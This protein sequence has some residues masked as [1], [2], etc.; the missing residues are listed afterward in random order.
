MKIYFDGCSF[1]Y[2]SEL[3]DRLKSRYSRLLCDH[4]DA[5]EYNI[6]RGGGS[7]RRIARN[8]LEHDLSQYDMVVLQ[9]TKRQRT[10]YYSYGHWQRVSWAKVVKF[11]MLSRNQGKMYSMK[12]GK[13]VETEWNTRK[14]NSSVFWGRSEKNDKLEDPKEIQ[15]KVNKWKNKSLSD[16]DTNYKRYMKDRDYWETYYREIYN[17]DYGRSEEK[18][19]YNLFKGMLKDKPHVILSIE[20]EPEVPVDFIIGRNIPRVRSKHDSHPNEEGH[21]IICQEILKNENLL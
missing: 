8:L 1:T 12:D 9:M 5:E 13:V 19:Y 4:F 6:A 3:K 2:G 7:N 20:A 18:I 11:G 17:D 21:Q 14:Q 16:S 15:H 10:E